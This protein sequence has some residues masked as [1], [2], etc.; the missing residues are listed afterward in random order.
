MI[1]IDVVEGGRF[2]KLSAVKRTLLMFCDG[3]QKIITVLFH[4]P[5]STVASVDEK[6]GEKF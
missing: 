4:Q 3:E 6:G 1:T 2:L 5:A